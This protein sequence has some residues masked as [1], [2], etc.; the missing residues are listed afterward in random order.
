ME[1]VKDAILSLL[2]LYRY[3]AGKLSAL[4]SSL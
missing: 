1:T 4:L 3:L 2:Q